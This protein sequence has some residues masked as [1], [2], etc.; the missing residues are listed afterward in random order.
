MWNNRNFTPMLL[1][2]IDKPFNSKNY[3][4]ELKFDGIRALI[5]VNSKEI[6]VQT[7]NKIDVTNLFPE[8]DSIKKLVTKNTIFDGEIV[9]FNNN[10]PSFS[11]LQERLHLK[12]KAKIKELSKTNKVVFVCFD[13]LYENKDLTN[14]SLLKRKERLSKYK[15]NDVFIKNKIIEEN[16]IEFFK[17]VKKLKLEGIVAKKKD[18]T[19]EINER[20]D[21]WVKIKNL[22]KD[23]FYI[24]G[25][26][27][28]DLTNVITLLLGFYKNKK[29]TYVGKVSM[30]KKNMLYKKIKA[31]KVRKTS[32]FTDYK[33]IGIFIS[34]T[35]KCKVEFLEW[36]KSGHLREPIFKN[37]IT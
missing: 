2:E 27:E 6:Y 8:L 25:Y 37:E 34:P 31:K 33:Q 22:K 28:K 9:S 15:E 19:Y 32:P 35:L 13:I 1:K 26:I 5:F 17:K 14:S 18:S 36:T 10:L 21:N 30:N 24:G 12:N 7:R 3:I 11:K 23:I 29:F 20:T 4:F 16:G